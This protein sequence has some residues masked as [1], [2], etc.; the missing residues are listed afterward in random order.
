MPS[1]TSVETFPSSGVMIAFVTVAAII[2][3][4]APLATYALSLGALGLVHVLAEV[5]YVDERFRLRLGQGLVTGLLALLALIVSWRVWLALGGS[6]G[7]AP[8]MTE[9]L[10]LTLLAITALIAVRPA[11]VLPAT[12]AAIVVVTL[13]IGA[14]WAPLTALVLL[15]VLHNLTPI[16]FLAERLT[17]AQR[18]RAMV[19]S[20]VV[21]VVV[22]VIIGSRLLRSAWQSAG[23]PTPPATLWRVG[24]VDQHLGVFVPPTLLDNAN[25]VDLF[26]AVV[27]L[28]VLHYAVVIHILPRLGARNDA[29]EADPAT[30]WPSNRIFAVILGTVAVVSLL[31]FALSFSDA[32][33][34]YGIFAAFHAWLEVPILLLA[35]GG[36]A[37]LRERVRERT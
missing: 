3:S 6:P 28:Q 20:V 23:L 32:R 18:H 36:G 16:G 37:I 22:P 15:A 12:V 11:G 31:A 4:V 8:E 10:L 17:G 35:L 27:F 2:A 33:R 29:S 9:L 26:A 7:P 24:D 5:R 13:A 1:P 19:T 30:G 34:I 25:A 14:Y 21:F